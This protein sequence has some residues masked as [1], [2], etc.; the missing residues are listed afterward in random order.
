MQTKLRTGY[1]AFEAELMAL[2]SDYLERSVVIAWCLAER[3]QP[4]ALRDLAVE[5]KHILAALRALLIEEG[6]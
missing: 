6:E 3:D 5:R 1:E 2:N 4:E